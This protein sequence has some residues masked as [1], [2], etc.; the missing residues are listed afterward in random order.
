[1]R[2]RASSGKSAL[3]EELK[4]RNSKPPSNRNREGTVTKKHFID[5]ADFIKERRKFFPDDT[6]EELAVWLHSQN[7]N[8]LRGRWMGYIKG[9]CG[10]GGGEVRRENR[11]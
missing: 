10:P 9:E 7:G 11:S 5:L 3:E 4:L 8:F 6:I 1:M 2:C